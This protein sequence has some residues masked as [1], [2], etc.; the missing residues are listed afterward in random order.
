MCIDGQYLNAVIFFNIKKRE[1]NQLP[2]M[3]CK[4][5]APCLQVFCVDFKCT[6]HFLDKAIARNYYI[7]TES[8]QLQQYNV[9]WFCKINVRLLIRFEVAKYKSTN[10]PGV[11]YMICPTCAFNYSLLFSTAY[12]C[13]CWHW[14]LI[15]LTVSM[16]STLIYA[17]VNILLEFS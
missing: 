2:L 13:N 12:Q 8:D 17:H 15:C 1:K 7:W 5:L 11:F 4:S 10:R 16:S 9:Q 6:W 14:C 3:G